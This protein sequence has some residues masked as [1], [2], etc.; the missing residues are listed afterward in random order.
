M[1][2]AACAEAARWAP[3]DGSSGDH[4]RPAPWVA[5]NVSPVQLTED[6]FLTDVV[7]ALATSGLVPDR[8]CLEITETAAITDLHATVDRLTALRALGV[9]VALD[10]F[11]TGH[12]SLTLLR[13][14]PVDSV[15]I[16]RSFVDRVTSDPADAVLVRLVVEAAHSLGLRVCAEGVET[17]DQ[18]RQLV[19]MGCDSAQG[20]LFGRPRAAC[21]DTGLVLAAS[22]EGPVATGGD[23][24]L[25]LGGRDELILVTTPEGRI[26]Y[27]SASSVPLLGWSPHELVGSRMVDHL[28]P[29][30]RAALDAGPGGTTG[31]HHTADGR[32]DSTTV[33]RVRHRHGGTRWLESTT[34]SIRSREGAVREVLTVSR[35]VTE[36]VETHQA[37][38]SS[39]AMFRHAFDDAPIG[40][41]LTGLD[42]SFLRVNKALA[43]LLGRSTGDLATATVAEVTHPD[44]LATDRANVD[45]LRQGHED[46]H[47]VRKRYL[48]PDGTPVPVLVHATVVAGTTGAPAH[49]FAHVLPQE[50]AGA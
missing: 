47:Q 48:R 45:L 25:P 2:R 20:W 33:H 46:T 44:D 39:E 40:M 18:A 29:E 16:D 12:S 22:R 41:A 6:E 14:L 11:G 10:D 8:L 3:P 36:K 4:L 5:V 21:P 30:D 28:V 26:S 42:G 50:P 23:D 31:D 43:A 37:L 1:L 38:A 15:K 35:D 32:A 19:S 27:A 9:R 13:H 7:E 49:V 34:R 24:V 17:E